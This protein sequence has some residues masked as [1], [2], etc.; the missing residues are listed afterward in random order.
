MH[1]SHYPIR[2][3]RT[4]FLLRASSEYIPFP[5]MTYSNKHYDR[6]L[7]RAYSILSGEKNLYPDEYL[8]SGSKI[9]LP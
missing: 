6:F 3:R 7:H 9:K 1:C 5:T 4:M 2:A 8:L